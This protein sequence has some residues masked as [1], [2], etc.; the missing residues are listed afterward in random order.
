MG[1][2]FSH[3]AAK[4]AAG[5][6]PSATNVNPPR[7]GPEG[8]KLTLKRSEILSGKNNFQL[9]FQ[10]GR[11]IQGK[12]LHCLV[13]A[14]ERLRLREGS[15]SGVGFTAPGNLKRAVDRNRLK[16]LLREAYRVNK[17]ILRP[18][19]KHESKPL[20][21]VF[22][23]SSSITKT[24]PFPTYKDV[25]ADMKNLLHLLAGTKAGVPG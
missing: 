13:L 23:Y 18:R 10:Q 4:K 7:P 3:A 19:L 22:Q 16:R 1:E 24:Q 14:D 20:E 21:L 11:K 17:A 8:V 25:E 12:Y 9:V 6:S 15:K 2:K 5:S